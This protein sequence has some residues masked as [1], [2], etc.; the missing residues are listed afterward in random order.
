[1]PFN[2]SLRRRPRR[3]KQARPPSVSLEI[4]S[5]I[6]STLVVKL[7]YY[8]NNLDIRLRASTHLTSRDREGALGD[9]ER[10][11]KA[12][13]KIRIHTGCGVLF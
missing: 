4:A 11:S 5:P 2:K 8:G 13:A 1:M 6:E 12:F 9:N 10:E 7:G 3:V